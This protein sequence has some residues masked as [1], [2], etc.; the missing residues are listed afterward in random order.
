MPTAMGG[1]K[2]HTNP[3]PRRC[4]RFPAWGSLGALTRVA[5]R[6]PKKARA[7]AACRGDPARLS[8]TV[9]PPGVP[10]EPRSEE[11]AQ[12]AEEEDAEQDARDDAEAHDEAEVAED[13][14][15]AK[16][17]PGTEARS[18]APAAL[19]MVGPRWLMAARTR[20]GSGTWTAR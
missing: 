6:N 10:R 13:E 4:P 2:T 11:D 19:T 15:V 18:D 7:L 16:R 14:D 8:L 1:E 5:K 3:A 17:Q 9:S 12:R 20:S